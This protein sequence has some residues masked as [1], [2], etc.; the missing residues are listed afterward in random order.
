[1]LPGSDQV[2]PCRVLRLFRPPKTSA[3]LAAPTALTN[4][5]M[6]LHGRS[7]VEKTIRFAMSRCRLC[8]RHKKLSLNSRQAVREK[9]DECPHPRRNQARGH[10]GVDG[11]Q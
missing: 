4:A 2:E 9:V 1:M 6:R 8:H 7:R 10:H 11:H 5:K 3:S